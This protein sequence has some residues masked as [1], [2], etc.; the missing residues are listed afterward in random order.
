MSTL[1]PRA[2][3]LLLDY[4]GVL[5][6]RDPARGAAVEERYGLPPGTVVA[7]MMEWTRYLPA[8]T[9]RVSRAEWFDGV[10]EA[11][12]D[13]V[14]GAER[15]RHLVRE[16][17]TYRGEIDPVVLAFVRDVRAAGL[18]VALVSNATAELADDLVTFGIA[19]DLDAVVNSSVI[20][21]HKPAPEFFRA[22][23]EAIGVPP[24]H[25]LFVDDTDRNVRGARVAGLSAYRYDPP[26][27]LRY[28][29]AALGLPGP[30]SPAEPRSPR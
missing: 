1:R 2:E 19:G 13:R 25:C 27:D 3:A 10:A 5:C 21:V 26:D 18:P 20:G 30:V 11:L 24:K 7:T 14:G 17:D 12:A 23:C 9:G 29:R 22:A 16:L 6:R 28:A 15:A 4:D 8:V